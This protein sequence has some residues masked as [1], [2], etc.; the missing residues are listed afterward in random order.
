MFAKRH[1]VTSL[2]FLLVIEDGEVAFSG[3]LPADADGVIGRALD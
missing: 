3:K 2:P 1:A